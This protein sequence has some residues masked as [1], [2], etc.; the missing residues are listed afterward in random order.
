MPVSFTVE[1][2]ITIYEQRI[3]QL[4]RE[5]LGHTLQV[6]EVKANPTITGDKEREA[7]EA[8]ENAIELIN[9]AYDVVVAKLNEI[10]Q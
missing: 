4:R 5:W 10:K 9:V 6:A 7:I 3:D 1:E 2:L 8:S